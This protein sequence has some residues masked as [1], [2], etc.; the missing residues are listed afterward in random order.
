MPLRRRRP[1]SLPAIGLGLVVALAVNPTIVAAT[2]VPLLTFGSSWRYLDDGSDLGTAWRSPTFDDSRWSLGAAPLGYGDDG[3]A[4]VVSFGPTPGAK[5]ITTYFRHTFQ[6]AGAAAHSQLKLQV[7]RD[8]GAGVYVNGVE[9]FRSNLPS[10]PVA[11]TTLASTPIGGAD[12][13]TPV[14]GVAGGSVLVEGSNVVAVEIHQQGPTSTDLGF[15]LA[16]VGSDDAPAVT[17]G[18]YLQRGSSTAM[19]IRWRT[20]V[21]TDSAVRFGPAAGT[22]SST[23]S[24]PTLTTEHEVSLTGLQPATRYRYSVGTTS[25]P[26]TGGD[27]NHFFD[28]APPPGTKR[29]TRIW[30]LGDSGTADANARA[31]RDAYDAFTGTRHTDLW[32]MLGDNAYP[33]GTDAE[34]QAAVFDLYPRW[35]RTSVLWPTLGNHDAASARSSTQ[36]G[37]YYDIFTL[38]A[39]GESGGQASGTEAYYSFDY[40]NIHFVCLDSHDTDRAPNGAM[41]QWL[42][43]DLQSTTADWVIAFWHHPPYS[44][45][46]HDSDTEQRLVD[47]RQNILPILDSYGVDLVLTGHSHAYE[48]SVLLDGHYGHS[49]T[50]GD[51]AQ[52]NGGR[53]VDAGSGRREGSGVYRKPTLGPAPHE[54]AVYVVAGSSGQVEGGALDHP[55]MFVSLNQLGSLVLDVE[56]SVLDATF[57]TDTQ[58]LA[59]GFT[60]VK[61]DPGRPVL[62]AVVPRTGCRLAAGA[63]LAVR[64]KG[65]RL[66]WRWTGPPSTATEIGQPGTTTSY[67]LCV[68]DA[69]GLLVGTAMP[70]GPRWKRA[71]TGFQYRDPRGTS[72]GVRSAVVR[73]GQS[74]ARGTVVATG[75]RLPSPA[76]PASLPLRTQLVNDETGVCWDAT[77]ATATKNMARGVHAVLPAAQTTGPR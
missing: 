49:S 56:G 59:D 46:S 30:V 13:V 39:A 21:P 35:L 34:Y 9:V 26:L 29:N 8:D 19:T 58:R 54:G 77:F 4:T 43:A 71:P 67:A 57:L 48:R 17:R 69:R 32:L 27:A 45:G 7:R 12:E 60:I 62:C 10:G 31:V 74:G 1:W 52:A 40:A 38:P 47:M 36:S 2:E 16:L 50:L 70:E 14:S 61:A 28:T 18:P 76:L 51:P 20:L 63:R 22:A 15:D 64:T 6:V 3:L 33:N 65:P 23:V 53:I 5:Y 75:V 37:V 68:Y 11:A 24:V 66:T 41:A 73:R 42:V 55:A 25:A 72:D 44:K